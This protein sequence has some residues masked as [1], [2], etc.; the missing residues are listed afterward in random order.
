MA[1]KKPGRKSAKSVRRE[2]TSK[3]S[4]MSEYFRFSESYTSLILGIVVVIIVSVLLISFVKGRNIGKTTPAAP[5][6]SSAKI[7]PE[8]DQTIS[9]TG[10]TYTV[11]TGDDLWKISEKVYNDGYKW[12]EIAR[13][14]KI[15][16]PGDIKAGTILVIPETKSQQENI[17]TTQATPTQKVQEPTV[18]VVL[19]KKIV[20]LQDNN[21][22]TAQTV[23]RTSITGGSYTVVKG[24]TLWD[25]AVRKY[26]DGYKWVAI[27]KANHLANPNLIHPGNVFTLP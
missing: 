5:E 15:I 14:N 4:N 1:G 13:V 21:A 19:G 2:K 16:N 27:A 3:D 17:V 12:V 24:D 7:E 9:S 23:Q 20:A 22:V 26:G 25:I 6:I 11:K 8:K 10:G 18:T